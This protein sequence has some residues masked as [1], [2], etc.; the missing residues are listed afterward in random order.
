MI[1]Y[2]KPPPFLEMIYLGLVNSFVNTFNPNLLDVG[3]IIRKDLFILQSDPELKQ[4]FPRG[5][6]IPAYRRL[7]NLKELLAPSRFKMRRRGTNKSSQ[8]DL[9][10][11]FLWNPSHFPVFRQA[12]NTPFIPDFLVILKTLF[13]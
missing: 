12:K 4:L 11:N 9:C 5:S 1:N 3:N 7:K 10:R 2:P 13:I 8:C 6:V